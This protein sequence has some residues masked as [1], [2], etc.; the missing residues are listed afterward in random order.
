MDDHDDVTILLPW[1]VNGTLDEREM[2][3]VTRHLETCSACAREAHA[4]LLEARAL[5]AEAMPGFAAFERDRDRNFA[6]LLRRLG[7]PNGRRGPLATLALAAVVVL[8]VGAGW[9]LRSEPTGTFRAL[10]SPADSQ[11]VVL[12]VIFDPAASE[13]DVREVLL[14]SGGTLLGTPSPKGVYRIALGSGEEGEAVAARLRDQP[15]VLWAG[16]EQP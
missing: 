3:R 2:A 11:H 13:R 1:Y 9:L 6:R 15:I 8:A 10:T 12:Q 16:I 5:H 14:A 7:R 4:T